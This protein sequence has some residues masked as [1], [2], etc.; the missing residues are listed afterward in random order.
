MSSI[1]LS[2]YR[3]DVI[4]MISSHFAAAVRTGLS[5]CFLTETILY[6]I[7]AFLSEKTGISLAVHSEVCID[8]FVYN[9]SVSEYTAEQI[10]TAI[11]TYLQ[12][13]VD[14]TEAARRTVRAEASRETLSVIDALAKLIPA[15]MSRDDRN[16]ISW[17]LEGIES[18]VRR[19]VDGRANPS[20]S[21]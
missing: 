1:N 9:M 19:W 20:P 4:E 6:N 7:I 3:G 15:G 17:D 10:A 21:P 2:V 8:F 5:G 13:C 16:A 18:R 11:F 14:S 12:G